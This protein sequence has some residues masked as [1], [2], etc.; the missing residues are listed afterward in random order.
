MNS[1]WGNSD[2]DKSADLINL[3]STLKNVKQNK[4]IKHFLKWGL[5]GTCD[6]F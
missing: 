4:T 6:S 1:V 5:S 3:L 2:F